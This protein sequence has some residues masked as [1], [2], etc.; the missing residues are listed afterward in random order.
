MK[1]LTAI[2]LL[3]A[4]ANAFAALNLGNPAPDF[5]LKDI[6]SGENVT[7]SGFKGQVVILQFWKNN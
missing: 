5:T 1:K 2:L 3:C 4:A 6:R 7:L